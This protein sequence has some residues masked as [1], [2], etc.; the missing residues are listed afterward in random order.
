M[1]PFVGIQIPIS[2]SNFYQRGKGTTMLSLPPKSS[3]KNFNQKWRAGFTLVELL[4]VIAIIGILVAL[5]LPAVQSAREAARR[6][7]CSNQVRQ[8]ALAIHNFENHTGAFPSSSTGS[9]GRFSFLAQILPHMEQTNVYDHIDLDQAWYAPVNL[10]RLKQIPIENFKCPSWIKTQMIAVDNSNIVEDSLL[11][12]HY[13]AVMGPKIECPSRPRHIYQ[14][15]PSPDGGDCR[16]GGYSFDGIMYIRSET[17]AATI[18]DGLSNTLLIG[19]LAWSEQP[20][21]WWPVGNSNGHGW[22]YGGR[23]VMHGI[24][25]LDI[26]VAKNNDQSF[27]SVHPG[28]CHF[29]LADASVHFVSESIDLEI[30]KQL[31][32]RDGGEVAPLP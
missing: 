8:L 3:A 15:G 25:S 24:N 31:A 19:E 7:Q 17:T 20:T 6:V 5:L 12:T 27:G 14:V 1:Y 9:P 13:F 29:A 32:S 11:A 4:V 16:G 2:I 10:E 26:F 18:R 22:S 21:R 30:Y 23:N 28:G